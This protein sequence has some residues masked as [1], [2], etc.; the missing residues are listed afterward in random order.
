MQYLYLLTNMINLTSVTK[1]AHRKPIILSHFSYRETGCDVVFAE[2]A[3]FDLENSVDVVRTNILIGYICCF[4]DA[5]A[6]V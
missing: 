3:L 1:G 6:F 4:Y 2:Y 5:N